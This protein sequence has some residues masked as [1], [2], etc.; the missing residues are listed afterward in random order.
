MRVQ[1]RF[2]ACTYTRVDKL[3]K[4]SMYN[5]LQTENFERNTLKR[6]PKFTALF[7]SYVTASS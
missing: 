4:E 7:S 2:E 1:R 3:L 6:S 5:K